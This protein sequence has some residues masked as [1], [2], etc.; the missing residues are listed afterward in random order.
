MTF[1]ELKVGDEFIDD[2][3]GSLWRK[4]TA[5]TAV[6]ATEDDSGYRVGDSA[7]FFDTERVEKQEA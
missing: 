6:K 5:N 3:F 2:A 7:P 1:S 4:E